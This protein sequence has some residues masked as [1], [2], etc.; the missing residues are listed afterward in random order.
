MNLGQ[1]FIFG[2]IMVGVV[3]AL[4]FLSSSFL[5]AKKEAK[6]YRHQ[7]IAVCGVVDEALKEANIE[8]ITI[9]PQPIED[10]YSEKIIETAV[11]IDVEQSGITY[12]VRYDGKLYNQ[13]FDKEFDKE[14]E[15][16]VV[17]WTYP[18]HTISSDFPTVPTVV[19]MTLSW[20]DFPKFSEI[21][22]K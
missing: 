18:P 7:L 1:R 21:G 11:R 13:Q 6:S 15:T 22:K 14:S 10:P 9:S 2:L 3:C 8:G 20:K 17:S 19:P 12:I 16:G 4:L 5:G